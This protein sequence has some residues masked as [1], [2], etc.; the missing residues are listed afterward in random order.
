MFRKINSCENPA[1]GTGS[2]LS[3]GLSKRFV[4]T[5]CVPGP[6]RGA[7]DTGVNR[8]P[9]L[10][11]R[12]AQSGGSLWSLFPLSSEAGQARSVSADLH[13]LPTQ[14]NQRNTIPPWP[15]NK[16]LIKGTEGSV[17]EDSS[18]QTKGQS[19]GSRPKGCISRR[20]IRHQWWSRKPEQALSGGRWGGVGHRLGRDEEVK[21]EA[22]PEETRRQR[23]I[24]AS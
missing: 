5:Y 21:R 12:S 13:P 14:A 9:C 7:G 18:L 11:S 3:L 15:G 22:K 8:T 17:P 2:R 10:P 1:G 16:A 24:A 19:P 20:E 23:E 6:A 4:H